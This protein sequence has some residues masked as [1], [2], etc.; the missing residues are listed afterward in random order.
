MFSSTY[1]QNMKAFPLFIPEKKRQ[2]GFPK[3]SATQRFRSFTSCQPLPF[4]RCI[5]VRVQQRQLSQLQ[6][7]GFFGGGYGNSRRRQE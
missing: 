3:I 6:F 7:G 4:Y 5:I 2:I 1:I